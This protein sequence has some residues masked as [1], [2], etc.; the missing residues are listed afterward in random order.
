[1]QAHPH[2][3]RQRLSPEAQAES[4]QMQI[5]EARELLREAGV[6]NF[7]ALKEGVEELIAAAHGLDKRTLAIPRE[8]MLAGI[9][10]AR[11]NVKW[12]SDKPEGMFFAML[13][14]ELIHALL[15]MLGD[16][17]H[18]DLE[19]MISHLHRK[20]HDLMREIGAPEAPEIEAQMRDKIVSLI[21]NILESQP[22]E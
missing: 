10:Q 6:E 8:R 14:F 4:L 21:T 22:N 18:W 12:L 17:Y 2:H 19:R 5:D 16:A 7:G 11:A 15:E 20:V 1:M 13:H 9:E 3:P